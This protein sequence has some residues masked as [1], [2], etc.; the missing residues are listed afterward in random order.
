MKAI[1]LRQPWALMFSLGIKKN[2]TRSW[3]TD[4]RGPLAIAST[5]HT[6]RAEFMKALEIPAV[7]KVLKSAKLG[8][9]ETISWICKPQGGLV[10][11]TTELVDVV[12]TEALLDRVAKK[13]HLSQEEADNL[14]LGDY[15]PGRF[16]WIC[17]NT[18]RIDPAPPC[19]GRQRLWDFPWPFPWSPTEHRSVTS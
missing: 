11:A 18:V 13:D 6:P 10:V 1:S 15:S 19:N 8:Y 9:V 5:K 12:R 16:V 4:Y 17:R 2:E 14:S 3:S 7:K